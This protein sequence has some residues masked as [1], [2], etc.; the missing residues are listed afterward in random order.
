MI[1]NCVFLL[2]SNSKEDMIDTFNLKEVLSNERTNILQNEKMRLCIDC[3]VVRVVI[4]DEK[5]E[6]LLEK[7]NKYFYG[8][9]YGQIQF[10]N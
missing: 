4:F 10:I 5:N 3:K 6:A 9:E 1:K 8:E 7:I 2:P